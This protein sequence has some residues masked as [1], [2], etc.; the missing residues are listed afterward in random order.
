MHYNGIVGS[1]IPVRSNGWSVLQLLR[2]L[3][4]DG[5]IAYE[6]GRVFRSVT[7]GHCTSS[8]ALEYEE[9]MGRVA[10]NLRG[11]IT[12]ILEKAMGKIPAQDIAYDAFPPLEVAERRPPLEAMRMQQEQKDAD[13]QSSD[14]SV[15]STDTPD[16][17]RKMPATVEGNTP[18]SQEMMDTITSRLDGF[19]QKL[20]QMTNSLTDLSTSVSSITT[21]TPPPSLE[22]VKS[23]VQSLLDESRERQLQDLT[24]SIKSMITNPP[25]QSQEEVT[26]LVQRLLNEHRERQL[27]DLL[28][29]D[30][31]NGIVNGLK[32]L[33]T[34]TP[35][36]TTRN[37]DTPQSPAEKNFPSPSQVVYGDVNA[38]QGADKSLSST[39]RHVE[40][41]RQDRIQQIEK[42]KQSLFQSVT[43]VTGQL[44]SPS[45][46]F[47]P[48]GPKTT[49]E[50][51]E[52]DFQAGQISNLTDNTQESTK[53]PLKP[54]ALD[55]D[56]EE[57]TMA[58]GSTGAQE[59]TIEGSLQEGAAEPNAA[60]EQH[61]EESRTAQSI[62]RRS[63]R[64]QKKQGS[65][66][67][68][69]NNGEPHE[70]EVAR[71]SSAKK[72]NDIRNYL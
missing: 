45:Q 24:Q 15:D 17:D 7:T 47:T 44:K 57:A 72:Q 19:D 48:A 58:E 71:K 66:E 34:T 49:G 18:L 22:E 54:T 60:P 36:A 13:L 16:M 33:S 59:E 42:S 1:E 43:K 5:G 67:E 29:S 4:S 9:G 10:W 12:E 21:Y 27:Q 25:A 11:R 70:E 20:G 39:L 68:N 8:L 53:S 6:N 51:E 52:I 64:I 35:V 30:T 62:A 14:S 37:E 31:V 28:Q 55:S 41:Y 56:L 46:F 3:S 40:E 50:E 23:L 32:S 2:S 61:Q 38:E 65:N 26:S 63:A 69:Q